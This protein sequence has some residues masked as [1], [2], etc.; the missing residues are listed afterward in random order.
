MHDE[1]HFIFNIAIALG[2]ALIGGWGAH[3]L[4]L[5]PLVGYLLAGMAIGPLATN[6]VGNRQEIASLAEVGVVFLMFVLGIEFSL[7]E[8]ARAGLAAI[9]GTL[10]Q[11]LLLIGAGFGIGL[12]LGWPIP[13]SLFLGGILSI[14]STMVILKTLMGRGETVESHGRLLLAML[15]VQDL[16]VVV[17]MLL[18]PRLAGGNGIVWSEVALLMLKG[19]LFIGATLFLGVR[20]IPPLIEKVERLR[21]PELSILTAAVLALGCAAISGWLGLSPALGAFMGGLL[22]TESDFEHSV[23]A[24]V[25]PMRDLFATLFFVSIGMLMDVRF[26]ISHVPQVLG[27]ALLFLLCKGVLTMVALAPFGVRGKTLA[28]AGLGMVPLGE[29]NF[30]MAGLGRSSGALSEEFYNWILAATLPTIVLTPAAFHFA[31][32]LTRM[33]AKWPLIGPVFVARAKVFDGKG[34]NENPLADHAIVVGYGRVGRRVARGLR[35]AGLH[36]V[37]MEDD[38]QSLES[39]REAGF[40]VIYGDATYRD[41]LHAAHPEKAKMIVVA[42]PDFGATR[43]VVHRSR[44]LDPEGLIVARARRAEDDVK[45]REAGASAV[46]APELAGALMLLDETLLLLGLPPQSTTYVVP[47]P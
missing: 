4:R 31:P 40:T 9:A 10:T 45:L 29:F 17:L 14:S 3:A 12:M 32:R 1:L 38:W 21:S 5:S 15:I 18:L 46:V 8:L 41:V 25:G 42:L 23:M 22:L 39:A 13:A 33:F 43:A 7:K 37:V 34:E 47:A 6:A 20:G 24:R 11:I 19:A 28:F 27:L 35:T 44:E 36:V 26:I 2:I 16:A 30:V